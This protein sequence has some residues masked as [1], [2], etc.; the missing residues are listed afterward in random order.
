MFLV[1]LMMIVLIFVVFNLLK[2]DC[3]MVFWY[4]VMLIILM[5][6]WVVFLIV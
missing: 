4:D 6:G 1:D 5:C 2:L 3:V